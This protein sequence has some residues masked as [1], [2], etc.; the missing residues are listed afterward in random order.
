MSRPTASMPILR[1][2]ALALRLAP[3]KTRHGQV[4]Y[5]LL[6][7]FRLDRFDEPVT[8]RLRSGATLPVRLSDFNGRMLFFFG[9]VDPKIVGT[10][11][12]LLREGDTLLDIGANHGVVGLLCAAAVGE[13]GAVHFVE[14]QPELCEGIRNAST[15]LRCSSTVHQIGLL[16]EDGEFELRLAARHTGAASLVDQPENADG[17]TVRVRVREINAFLDETA[18]AGAFGAK[19]DVEGAEERIIPSLLR[20]EGLRFL[21]FECNRDSTREFVRRAILD[22]DDGPAMAVFGLEKRLLRVRLAPVQRIEDLRGFDDLV[23]V[24][25][26]AGS[27]PDRSISPAQLAKLQNQP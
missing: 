22:N 20:R 19:V 21:L 18:G 25:L 17:T 1:A 16:D 23:V 14:P 15:A 8:A 6:R 7:I 3:I 5:Y 4:C 13:S 12:A 11:R 9:T 26:D 24:Q 2:I 27:V 10:C